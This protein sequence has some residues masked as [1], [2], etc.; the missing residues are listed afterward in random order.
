M[1]ERLH[2]VIQSKYRNGEKFFSIYITA[3][4]PDRT[5]TLPILT[6]LASS[7][8]DFV[9]LGIPFSDPIADGPTIQA[10]STT[11][12]QNGTTLPWILETVE[13]FRKNSDLPVILMGYANPMY[14]YGIEAFVQDASSAGVDGVIIPDFP[15][16]V[17][18]P[19]MPYFQA[20]DLDVIYLIAPN[21]P[22]HRIQ[23]LAENTTAFLYCTAYT[24]VTGKTGQL[25]PQ[26]RE[27][28]NDLKQTLTV[29]Y[30]IGFGIHT[31][32]QV[33]HYYQLADGVVVGS[34]FIRAISDARLDTVQHHVAQFISRLRAY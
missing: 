5:L 29:P 9:E 30:V 25:T 6:A 11:A 24:G 12:L 16:E 18:K 2:S 10:A 31:A 3:G 4:Y 26:Y 27:F 28:F 34:A 14:Q 15:L 13:Q 22:R 33:R 32:Q 8:V 21:T 17:A 7:G 1:S 20:T 19:L 23:L